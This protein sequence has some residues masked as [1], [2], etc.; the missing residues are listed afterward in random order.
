MASD[1]G[2][3]PAQAET[4]RDTT[5]KVTRRRA[6]ALIAVTTIGFKHGRMPKVG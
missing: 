3:T 5:S 2:R 4:I 6:E 1:C